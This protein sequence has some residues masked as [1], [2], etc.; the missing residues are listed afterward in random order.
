MESNEFTSDSVANDFAQIFLLTFGRIFPSSS[1]RGCDCDPRLAGPSPGF[2]CMHDRGGRLFS[3]LKIP[4]F[5]ENSCPQRL[6]GFPSAIQSLAEQDT[7][8][9]QRRLDLV[10][11]T[12]VAW[13]T[14]VHAAAAKITQLPGLRTC[15][16]KMKTMYPHTLFHLCSVSD[17]SHSGTHSSFQSLLYNLGANLGLA[18]GMP[19]G[20]VADVCHVSFPQPL[21]VFITVSTSLWITTNSPKSFQPQ[22]QS[23]RKKRSLST[24]ASPSV[25]RP[26]VALRK[27]NIVQTAQPAKR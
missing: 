26:L 9:L 1:L 27:R 4:S 16:S 14:I 11:N 15:R 3:R 10:V 7:M 21:L 12:D 2:R 23:S 8:T 22:T 6:P 13:R 25:L 17:P 24:P 5:T 18:I 20:L 19:S